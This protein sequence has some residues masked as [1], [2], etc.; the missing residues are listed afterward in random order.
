MCC[1]A[2]AARRFVYAFFACFSRAACGV[3]FRARAAAH[4]RSSQR[5]VS[6]CKSVRRHRTSLSIDFSIFPWLCGRPAALVYDMMPVS[7]TY[8][9]IAS[10]TSDGALSLLMTVGLPK[11]LDHIS[12]LSMTNSDVTELVGK[13]TQNL[14]NLSCTT[15]AV[16]FPLNVAAVLLPY[17]PAWSIMIVCPTIPLSRMYC[18]CPTRP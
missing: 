7:S 1:M 18:V 5:Y 13:G 17:G 16:R 4:M 11:K 10:P 15:K 6:P 9:C 2:R 8:F 12:T 3:V 14:L